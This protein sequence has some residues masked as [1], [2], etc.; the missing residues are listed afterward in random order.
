MKNKRRKM[1]ILFCICALFLC[2]RNTVKATAYTNRIQINMQK[3]TY[4]NNGGTVDLGKAEQGGWSVL[5]DTTGEKKGYYTTYLYV[6]QQE[7]IVPDSVISFHMETKQ[8]VF[9][10]ADIVHEPNHQSYKCADGSLVYIKRDGEEQYEGLTIKYGT[11]EIP[12]NFKGEVYLPIKG[13]GSAL[14]TY[15]IG[16]VVVLAQNQKTEFS[17]KSMEIT[18]GYELMDEVFYSKIVPKGKTSVEI[19]LH[20]QYYNNY[21]VTQNGKPAKQA[22]FYLEQPVEGVLMEHDGKLYVEHTAEPQK[23]G[24]MVEVNHQLNVRYEIEIVKSWL[25]IVEDVDVSSFVVPS[26]T[27]VGSVDAKLVIPYHLLRGM[28]LVSLGGFLIFYCF[29]IRRRR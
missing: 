4:K 14:H 15:G 13:N 20:G 7:T 10:N 27:Q 2:S 26:V 11:F 29:K 6:E 25:Q 8:N 22:R 1:G 24:I 3:M 28:I 21:S 18:K 16:F 23:I 17:M 19:P 9:V 5:F 12:E